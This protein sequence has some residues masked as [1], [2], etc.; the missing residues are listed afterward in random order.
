ME[1]LPLKPGNSVPRRS[2]DKVAIIAP[3]EVT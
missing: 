2:K 3:V 1:R